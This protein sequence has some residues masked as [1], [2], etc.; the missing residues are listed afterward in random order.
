MSSFELPDDRIFIAGE[1]RQ[2][3]GAP[4]ESRFPAD[5]SLNRVL[6]GASAEDVSLAIGRAQEAANAP[7]WRRLRPHERA[8]FLYRIAEG[9]ARDADRIAFVQSRDTGK[10]LTET[11]A[12]A[13]SAAGTFRYMAAALETMEDALTPSRGDYLSFSVHEPLGVTAGITPWNSPIASDAQKV[14][15]ALAAGNAILLKPASWSPLVCLELAR[16][17]EESG[18]PAGLFSALPGSGSIVGERLVVDPA[19]RKVSFTGGTE[20][21]R[22]IARKAAEKLMPVSLELGGKSPTIVFDDAD[23][24]LAVAGVMFGVFSSTGQSCIAGSRLFVQRGVYE[25]FV[26][27]LVAATKA[28]R[29]GHSFERTTQVAPLI[30]PDHRAEVESHVARALADGGALL[31]GGERPLGAAYE[32]GNYYLPTIIAGLPNT[33]ALCREEVFGPVLAVLPFDDEAEVIAQGNDNDYG[34]AC[35]I[36]TRDFPRAWRV[37]RAIEAGTVWINTYKQFSIATPFGGV[38][39]SGLGREKGRE[40]IRAWMAQK[41]IYHDMSGLPHPWAA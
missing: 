3:R 29:V 22:G 18:L 34:L 20:V 14:A 28:L 25:E 39:D 24:D 10:T 17:V 30:H 19:I 1:W 21:G 33:A 26:A 38:K 31:A 11:K 35:G 6:H 9:I 2:G 41:S 8:T 23:L 32:S 27:K 12:L 37:G 36:Y 4:I 13:M 16:I 15:P 7:A 40:G 5:G